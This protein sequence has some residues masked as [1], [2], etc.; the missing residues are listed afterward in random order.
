MHQKVDLGHKYT[1]GLLRRQKLIEIGH[2]LKL[3]YGEHLGHGLGLRSSQ[4]RIPQRLLHFIEQTSLCEALNLEQILRKVCEDVLG[5]VGR[6]RLTFEFF[7][8]RCV[9]ANQ[10]VSLYI[11]ILVHELDALSDLMDGL[12]FFLRVGG[13]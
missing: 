7:D 9:K 5:H 1:A 10:P 11:I 2:Q 12:L 4:P 8:N 3:N 13:Q 6:L